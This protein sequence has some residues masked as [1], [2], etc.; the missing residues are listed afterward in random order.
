MTLA[1]RNWKRIYLGTALL[2]VVL[3][4]AGCSGIRASKGVSPL[5]FLLPGH[6]L[7]HGQMKSQTPEPM[8]SPL[9]AE[10]TTMLARA[11]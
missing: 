7:L 4:G 2:T 6:F 3:S 8:D 11:N 10:P 1:Q 9:P 5:D